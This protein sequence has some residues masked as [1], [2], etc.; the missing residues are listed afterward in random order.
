MNHI[1]EAHEE[2]ADSFQRRLNLSPTDS[3]RDADSGTEALQHGGG[4]HC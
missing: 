4:M 1:L 2:K 3:K